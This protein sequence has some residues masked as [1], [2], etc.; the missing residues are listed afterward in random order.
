MF[1][2]LNAADYTSRADNVTVRLHIQIVTKPREFGKMFVSIN[3][4]GQ[5][6]IEFLCIIIIIHKF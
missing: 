4:S 5:D 2:A 3:S 1:T 6:F